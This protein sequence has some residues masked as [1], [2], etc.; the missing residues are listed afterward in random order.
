MVALALEANP[1]LTWRDMQHLIVQSSNPQ[2]LEKSGSFAVNGAGWKVSHSYGFGLMDAGRMCELAKNWEPVGPLK[3]I[4]VKLFEGGLAFTGKEVLKDYTVDPVI[5]GVSLNKIKLETV[6]AVVTLEFPYRGMLEIYLTSPEGTTSQ[7]LFKRQND[8]SPHGFKM[9]EFMSVLHWDEKAAGVWKLRI[10]NGGSILT[11]K[12]VLKYFELIFTG[13]APE[14]DESEV[15]TE[16]IKKSA[17]SEDSEEEEIG[18]NVEVQGDGN[19]EINMEEKNIEN[20]RTVDKTKENDE[21]QD[22]SVTEVPKNRNPESS[23]PKTEVPPTEIISLLENCI[24]GSEKTCEECKK[25]TFLHL[26]TCNSEC[27]DKFAKQPLPKP[28]CESCHPTC[29]TC[30]GSL[31]TECKSCLDGWLITTVNS[32]KQI[33]LTPHSEVTVDK[34]E[35]MATEA[36][37]IEEKL[38][39]KVVEQVTEKNVLSEEA[40]D[41]KHRVGTLCLNF[42]TPNF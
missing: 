40:Q 21:N 31:A 24:K 28:H 11:Q 16:V 19:P 27:P 6:T 12:G 22:P 38:V 30:L 41:L 4:G 9:W 33:T 14:N 5:N 1:T 20:D 15:V 29:A 7:M 37:K 36:P 25:G 10:A 39:E 23:I 26:G 8:R 32:C 2:V 35:T 42:L 13:T 34:P 3:R 18:L 17:R